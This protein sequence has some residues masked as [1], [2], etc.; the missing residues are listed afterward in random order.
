MKKSVLN[1]I[2]RTRKNQ[3]DAYYQNQLYGGQAK[4]LRVFNYFFYRLLV[5]IGSVLFFFYFAGL[6]KPWSAFWAG[7]SVLIIYHFSVNYLKEKKLRELTL[8]INKKISEEE[9]WRRIKTMDKEGFIIFIRELLLK[10]P[11]F[12]QVKI[13]EQYEDGIDIFAKYH[14]E[15][16]AIQCHPLDGDE[17][18]ESKSA[19]EFSRGMSR[20]KIEKG[21][22]ISTTDFR[23]DT[24]RFCNLIK[25]KRQIKLLGAKDVMQMAMDAGKFPQKDE[26]TDLILKKIEHEARSFQET[27]EKLFAKPQ[28]VPYFFYGTLLLVG[29]LL[30]NFNAKYLYYIGA[31]GLYFLGIIGLVLNIQNKNRKTLWGW[32]DKLF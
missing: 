9:F 17:M 20:S 24:K 4:Y 5:L 2:R 29:G 22:I 18:V 6:E 23:E 25:D 16:V 12:T 19:R 8:E 28:I 31:G 27:R 21:I 1:I 32:Q 26:I 3:I 7:V 14:K 13:N 11:S 10:L 15:I 30:F